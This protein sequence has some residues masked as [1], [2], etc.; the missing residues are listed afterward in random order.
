MYHLNARISILCTYIDIL[1]I[2]TSMIEHQTNLSWH[3]RI[4]SHLYIVYILLFFIIIFLLFCSCHVLIS[5][6]IRRT[7]LTYFS[8][9]IEMFVIIYIFPIPPSISIHTRLYVAFAYNR[10]WMKMENSSY[11]KLFRNYCSKSYLL[12]FFRFRRRVAP[13]TWMVPRSAAA[14]TPQW[15]SSTAPTRAWRGSQCGCQSS[16][17]RWTWRTSAW[18]RWKGGA[19][20]KERRPR[21]AAAGGSVPTRCPPWRRS[22]TALPPRGTPAGYASSRA[23]L[24]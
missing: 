21:G 5:L 1:D 10:S 19:C 16:R 7:S 9:Q 3:S 12:M 6:T 8:I 13:C 22:P 23:R 15:S 2:H 11:P 18:A 4:H 14:P 24:M 20:P 17:W